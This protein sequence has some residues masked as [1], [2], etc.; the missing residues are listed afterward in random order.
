[1]AGTDRTQSPTLGGPRVI[2]IEPQLSENVGAV[3][4]AMLNCG[5]DQMLLVNPREGWPNSKAYAMASGATEV[6]E[7]AQLY[8]TVEEAVADVSV[9]YATTARPR[10]LTVRVLTPREA[11]ADMRAVQARG[12]KIGVLFG[13]ERSGMTND[14][15]A[16][17]DTV[18]SV[19]L[20]PAYSSL[21]LGQAVLLVAYEWFTAANETPPD[22]L[23]M[24]GT[25]LAEKQ[26]L[27]GLF[28]RL[29]S[30][31]DSGGFF[32]APDLRPTIMRNLQSMLQRGRLTEQ[33]VRT[34]HGMISALTRSWQNTQN[35]KRRRE[36]EKQ[37]RSGAE[38]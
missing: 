12:E 23:S 7:A 36:L 28:D 35:A 16:L 19:P 26:E 31:L 27:I 20:N 5:L 3:A 6:L 32:R 18:I 11:A 9:L 21:N 17:A 13:P 37:E 25:R 38:D 14:H 30:E 15:I 24:S 1:M 33:E 4:R 29:E 2:L 22:T 8:G 34:F 10:E